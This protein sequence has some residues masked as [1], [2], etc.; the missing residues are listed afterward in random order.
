MLVPVAGG[1]G[2]G[3]VEHR[4][5]C[6]LFPAARLPV[7][8][9]GDDASGMIGRPE[10]RRLGPGANPEQIPL[11][12]GG[13]ELDERSCRLGDLPVLAVLWATGEG[14]PMHAVTG[15]RFKR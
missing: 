2:A 11:V 1:V 12:V 10:D 4:A 5:R 6:R 9:G 13:A 14:R 3:V 7:E 8:V 15:E